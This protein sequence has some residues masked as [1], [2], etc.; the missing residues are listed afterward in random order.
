MTCRVPYSHIEIKKINKHL[1]QCDGTSSISIIYEIVY[2]KEITMIYK[3]QNKFI[4]TYESYCREI[5]YLKQNIVIP[6]INLGILQGHELNK[7][8]VFRYLNKAYLIFYNA[9]VLPA[10]ELY[11]EDGV[12]NIGGFN[13]TKNESFEMAVEYENMYIYL[14]NDSILRREQWI[15]IDT[16][17][18]SSNMAKKEV[19][20]F[21]SQA[22]NLVSTIINSDGSVQ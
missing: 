2:K 11:I 6:Y 9:Q 15:P 5:I 22:N 12:A 19:D 1:K 16:I 13:I 10:G 21:F 17:Y 7:E 4:D 20:D 18:S 3:I 14:M 8:H